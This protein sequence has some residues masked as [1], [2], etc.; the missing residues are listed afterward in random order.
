MG[1]RDARIDTYIAR[2]APFARPI[3]A[4]IRDVVHEACPSCEETIKWGFPN[5]VYDGRILC[6]MAAFKAHCT[7]GF[8]KGDQVTGAPREEGAMGSF[9][10]I[11]AV[12]DLPA[13]RTL[14]SLVRK[15]M[16][17]SEQRATAPKK[18]PSKPRPELP[19]PP[20]LAS[21]LR[22]NAK[23]NATFAAFPP[24]QRRE[25]IEWI[26]DAKSD[27]TRQRRLETTLEWLAAGKRRNWKYEK[28]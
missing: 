14:V 3:L 19:V 6:S 5:F 22:R 25:Y 26:S 2:S 24:S 23:A 8:W 11:T 13:R 21:A 12:S 27:D 16:K 15:A 18:A 4:H 10:R 9:G 17:V 20:D 1:A 7:F 28:R